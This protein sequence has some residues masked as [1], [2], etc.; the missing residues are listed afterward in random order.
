MRR[1]IAAECADDEG[2]VWAALFQ[3][4]PAYLVRARVRV[5]VRVGVRVR[6][7]VRV[8][9]RVTPTLPLPLP[10]RLDPNPNPNQVQPAY[11]LYCLRGDGGREALGEAHE[12][13]PRA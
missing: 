5:R 4:Q 10:L 7:R 3:V 6:G 11:A 12:A 13:P 8:R 9:V 1:E 2:E